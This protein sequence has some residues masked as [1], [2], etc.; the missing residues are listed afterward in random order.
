MKYKLTL[1]QKLSLIPIRLLWLLSDSTK[2][3]TWHEVKK[4][5]E[6]H[7]HKFTQPFTECGIKFL[8]CEYE[9][10]NLCEPIE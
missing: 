1:L 2:R 10:C 6:K 8:H 9:G 3:K 5:M 7:E 4:G